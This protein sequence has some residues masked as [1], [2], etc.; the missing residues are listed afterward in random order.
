MHA[1]RSALLF[2]M[3]SALAA[4]LASAQAPAPGPTPPPPGPIPPAP[5]PSEPVPAPPPAEPPS[6]TPPPPSEPPPPPPPPLPEV[7]LPA[8][9]VAVGPVA[10]ALEAPLDVIVV[11]TRLARTAGSAHVIGSKQ[12]ERFQYDDVTQALVS[13][14]GLYVRT[15]D[16]M[17]LRPNIGL[18]GVNPDRSKK[19][20]LLEDGI[21]FGPA[22]YSAPAA[23]YF[24]LLMRMTK[25]TVIKGPAA[26]SHGPQTVAGAIDL[27]TRAIPKRT[28]A[29]AD[30]ALGQYGYGK[31]HVYAG[32]STD[33]F[34]FLIE[35]ARLQNNG[36]KELLDDRDTGFVRNEWMVKASYDPAPNADVHNSLK[37]KLTYSDEVS[38]ESYLGLA[39]ADFRI[40]PNQ[41]YPVSQLDRMKNH[42]TSIVLTHVLEPSPDLTL[43]TNVYRHDYAR[44]WRKVNGFSGSEGLFDVLTRPASGRNPLLVDTLRGRNA[45][46]PSTPS[47]M[48]GPNDRDFVS[49]GVDT[50]LRL[51]KQTGAFSH[52][53][54]AGVRYHY[55]SIDRR[56]SQDAF[57]VDGEQLY[58]S[59]VGTEVAA[60]NLEYTHAL[61]LH[62]AYALTWKTLTLTPGLRAEMFRS[63]SDDHL[64][65][66]ENK[67]FGHAILPGVGAFWTIYKSIGVLAGVY[68]GFSPPPPG[69]GSGEEGSASGGGKQ[70]KPEKSVNYEGGLRYAQGAQR[71][72]AVAFYNDYRNLTDYCSAS[73][74]CVDQQIDA[75]FDA[76][77]ARIYGLEMLAEHEIPAG[78]VTVPLAVAYTFTRAEFLQDFRSEDPIFGNVRRADEIPYVP[79]HQVRAQLGVEHPRAGANVA[80]TY[81]GQMREVPGRGRYVPGFST[82]E[83]LV[84]DLAGYAKIWGP[85][86][87]YANIQNLFDRQYI[88]SRRPF[89]ARPNAPRWTHVG[90]KATF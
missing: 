22:P 72:E 33:H 44:V 64:T 4:P 34:G 30:V 49:S 35:G 45:N 11:G 88:V 6:P 8:E 48:I 55:D 12:L 68:Q 54:E 17:G 37:L 29:L 10:P 89:G 47:L 19:V 84:F 26:I 41:R 79:K 32:T 5:P 71:T 31:A 75:Q 74:G 20:T 1:R 13:T 18:R 16:G 15:E 36:F 82:E 86:S 73:S 81:V 3:I 25:V 39:D 65:R 85:L 90:I 42:R 80:L 46:A 70:I 77:K 50:R 7:T 60:F 21:L 24:P 87:L 59:G 51:S 9:P 69:S 38:N 52:K 76:G 57:R 43:T 83:Q 23:Y 62:A 61:A 2:A 40:N 58:P 78:K 56:H 14:P 27:Q 67:D 63:V 28:A 66:R 53:L